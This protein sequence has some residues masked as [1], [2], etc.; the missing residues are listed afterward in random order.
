MRNIF[1]YLEWI[2]TPIKK[3]DKKD[4]AIIGLTTAALLFLFASGFIV[5]RS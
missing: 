3:L 2:S 4:I 5:I 1:T